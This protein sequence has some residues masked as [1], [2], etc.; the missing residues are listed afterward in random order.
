MFPFFL[1][2]I[3]INP[4]RDPCLPIN[5]KEISDEREGGLNNIF[6]RIA[7]KVMSPTSRYRMETI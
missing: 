7:G 5:K 3:D 4:D 6:R 2:L 1:V